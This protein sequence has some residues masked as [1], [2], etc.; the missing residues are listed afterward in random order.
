MCSHLFNILHICVFVWVLFI[1]EDC[2][3]SIPENQL[4]IIIVPVCIRYHWL[5]QCD[6]LDQINLLSTLLYSTLHSTSSSYTQCKYLNICIFDGWRSS[7]W[8]TYHFSKKQKKN[9]QNKIALSS[10][11]GRYC[12]IVDYLFRHLQSKCF[13]TFCSFLS[14]LYAKIILN[15]K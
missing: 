6:Q 10:F 15:N 9:H 3:K 2:H 8:S 13:V 7:E 1:C 12:E 5:D 4:S 11:R 14:S